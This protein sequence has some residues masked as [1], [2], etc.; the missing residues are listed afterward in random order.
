MSYAT[1]V[2]LREYLVQVGSGAANDALLQSV[3]DRANSIVNE[4]L[5]FEFAPYGEASGRDVECR[6]RQ[7]WLE[8]PYH[9]AGTVATVEAISGRGTASEVTD[10][11]DGWLE[12]DDGRLYRDGG[13]APGWYR[14]TAQ[15][16]YGPAPASIVEVELEVAV[17]IWRGRDASMWQSDIGVE[18]AGAVSYNRA[19]T[20]AQRSIIDA[21]RLK[22]LGV[23]HA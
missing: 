3:L 11:L 10:A 8:V 18:G 20:W 12:E 6:H 9:N 22:Y 23:V 4:A 13:W 2:Q 1:V 5:G 17:N 15:W 19:L 7:R 14:I 16:G 21:V